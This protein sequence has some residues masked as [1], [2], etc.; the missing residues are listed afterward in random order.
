MQ[1][2]TT[3]TNHQGKKHLRWD[4]QDEIQNNNDAFDF[5]NVIVTN[6]GAKVVIVK[7]QEL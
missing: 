5:Q 6:H 4:W 3:S 2:E 7:G 1:K